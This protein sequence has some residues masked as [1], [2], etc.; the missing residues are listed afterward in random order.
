MCVC[1]CVCVCTQSCPTLCNPLDYSPQG[2]SVHGIF[3]A[4]ILEWI[5]IPFSRLFQ[6]VNNQTQTTK[7]GRGEKLHRS[8]GITAEEHFQK[9]FLSKKRWW[10]YPREEAV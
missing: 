2:S 6:Y 3:Q 7:L 1:V 8:K 4:R 5:V 9:M 10:R